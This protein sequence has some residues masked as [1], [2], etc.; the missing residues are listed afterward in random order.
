MRCT[1]HGA[2][3]VVNAIAAGRGSAFGI[4]LNVEADVNIIDEGLKGEIKVEDKR[5]NDFE[6]IRCIKEVIEE[7]SDE[8][9]GIEFFINSQIPIGKGLKSSS[10]VSNAVAKAIVGSLDMKI[11]DMEIIEIGIEASRRADLTITGALDDAYASYFGGLCLTDNLEGEV[12]VEKDIKKNS[13]VILIPEETVLT[14]SLK[15][16]DFEK[17]RPYVDLIFKAALD[18]EWKKASLLNG[19]VYS[20]FLGHDTEPMMGVLEFSEIVGLSGTGPAVYS[21]TEEPSRVEEV[22]G[23][24]GKTM[25]VSTR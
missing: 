21:V 3:T 18:G 12:L 2:L 11:D 6:L 10:A 13:A 7:R 17:I 25:E 24:L 23:Q 5:Y 16:V 4:D 20:S 14:N 15:D 1:A 19:L 9:F 8:E 22:W